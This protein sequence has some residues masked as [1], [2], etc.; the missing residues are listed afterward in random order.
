MADLLGIERRRVPLGC[1]FLA[2]IGLSAVLLEDHDLCAL[3]DRVLADPHQ[4]RLVVVL[5]PRL[6]V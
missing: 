2:D 6:H 5:D 1:A 3:G 4:R